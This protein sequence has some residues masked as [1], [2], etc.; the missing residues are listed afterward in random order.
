MKVKIT[1]LQKQI[2]IGSVLGDGY[3]EK[4]RYGSTRLQIKQSKEKKE[5]VFWLFGKLQTLCLS[6]PKQRKDNNQWYFGTRY[7]KE[8]TKFQQ[9][10]YSKRK[11][12]P[13]NI[14]EI[15]KSP[16]SLAI[17]Y[18]DDGTLDYRPKDHLAFSLMTNCFS[19]KEVYLLKE[20]LKKNFGL[21]TTVHNSS[22]RDKKRP[23]I[24]IGS[25]GR[26]RFLF[27]VKP[28]ILKCFSYK[29]PP[30]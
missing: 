15:L 28:Y 16:M 13:D 22:Y 12:I 19:R 20:S 17:W 29:L 8:L 26:N 6:K 23:K 30:V 21:K 9:L 3:L 11:R 14:S 25:K 1:S 2:I 24:Y 10:F 5:Y 4:N 27:L 7:L 18:M